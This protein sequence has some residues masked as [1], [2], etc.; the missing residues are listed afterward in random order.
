MAGLVIATHAGLAQEFLR[1]CEMIIGPTRHARAVG[2]HK[3]DSVETIRESLVMAIA[4]VKSGDDGGVVIMTDLF[5][6]TPANISISFLEAGKVE[7]L[8]GVNL[9]MILKFFNCQEDMPLAELAGIL[10]AFGQQ[11]ISMASDFLPKG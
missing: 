4:E 9:P 8:T 11:S 7:V 6:G 10:K 2:I 1:A 5:G 3:E